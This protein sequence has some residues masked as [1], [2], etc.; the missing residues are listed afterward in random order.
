MVNNQISDAAK[1]DTTI[2]LVRLSLSLLTALLFVKNASADYEMAIGDGYRYVNCNSIETGVCA[3]NSGGV[4]FTPLDYPNVGPVVELSTNKSHIFLRNVGRKNRSLFLGDTLEEIDETKSFF[5]VIDKSDDSTTGPLS[6]AEFNTH[7][8]VV[9]AKPIQ[10]REP[11][12]PLVR[13]VLMYLAAA[14]TWTMIVFGLV[15][16]QFISKEQPESNA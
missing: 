6:L 8:S 2:Y 9:L 15:L 5:F 11:R 4:I 12:N 14:I 1:M 10:W 16:R 7:N 13:T 3:A